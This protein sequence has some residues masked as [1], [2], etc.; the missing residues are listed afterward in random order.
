MTETV[1]TSH[2]FCDQLI[3]L[4]VESF[5]RWWLRDAKNT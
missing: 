4:F 2:Y 5:N 1:I 3:F